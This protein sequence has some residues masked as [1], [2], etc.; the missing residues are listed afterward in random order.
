MELMANGGLYANRQFKSFSMEYDF[1]S[2][3]NEELLYEM[4][5]AMA[6]NVRPWAYISISPV[7]DNSIP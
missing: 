5:V 6:Q 3:S 7:V 4:G 2:D 1:K